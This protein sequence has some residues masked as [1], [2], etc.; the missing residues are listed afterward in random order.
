MSFDSHFISSK[1]KLVATKFSYSLQQKKYVAANSA[2][3]SSGVTQ[4]T[5]STIGTRRRRTSFVVGASRQ[6]RFRSDIE[7][8][9]CIRARLNH[10]SDQ[11][12]VPNDR[13]VRALGWKES[14]TKP[15][16]RL[17][18]LQPLALGSAL[19]LRIEQPKNA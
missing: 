6:S 8:L 10:P 11:S 3:G 1:A 18:A 2:A 4:I 5:Q 12:R 7:Q 13:S 15:A 9:F 14:V 16:A 17:F 19:P